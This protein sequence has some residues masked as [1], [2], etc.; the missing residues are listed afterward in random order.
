MALRTI[1]AILLMAGSAAHPIGFPLTRTQRAQKLVEEGQG[2]ILRRDYAHAIESCT[3]A[4]DVEKDWVPAYLCRGEA[5]LRLGDPLANQDAQKALTLDP[6]SGEPYRL[7]GLLEYEAGRYHSAIHKF[8]EALKSVKLKPEAVPEVYYHRAKS[9]LNLGDPKMALEDVQRG[10][11]IMQGVNG[12]FEDWSFYDLRAEIYRSMGDAKKAE[13]EQ[14]RVIG[15]INERLKHHPE[16]SS[17]LLRR[18]A[19]ANAMLRDYDAAVRDYG[20]VLKADG[21]DVGTLLDRAT[22]LSLQG[23]SEASI[24]DADRALKINPRLPEALYRRAVERAKLGRHRPA[25]E[26]FDAYLALRPKDAQA[27]MERGVCKQSLEDYKGAVKDFD[28]A[29]ALGFSK[30]SALWEH[31]AFSLEMLGRHAGAL[32]AARKALALDPANYTAHTVRAQAGWALGRCA[33]AVPSLDWL[34]DKAPSIAQ[35]RSMR[36]ECRCSSGDDEQ[37]LLDLETAAEM[38]SKSRYIILSLALHHRIYLNRH[39]EK[40][41]AAELRRSMGYFDAAAALGKPDLDQK[42]GRLLSAMELSRKLKKV[43]AARAERTALL[44]SSRQECRVLTKKYRK[45]E[46][47]RKLCRA[48]LNSR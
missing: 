40:A 20:Q 22:V 7:L 42:L 23:K 12:D 1:S 45:N 38:N 37:G 33:D 30:D 15:L 6:T 41:S 9:R 24:Q 16:E 13:A 17:E 14:K 10:I 3:K 5:R 19:E 8:D 46:S 32:Y 26:D 2:Q 39:P 34:I 11:G 35:F 48:A 18:R 36:G 43:R 21:S 47:V 25:L 29:R 44:D 4:L 27:W 28:Q 31:R